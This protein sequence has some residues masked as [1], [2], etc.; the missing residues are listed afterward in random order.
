MG[1]FLYFRLFLTTINYQTIISSFIRF[2]VSSF[3]MTKKDYIIKMLDALTSINPIAKDMKTIV[4]ANAASD[5]MI[6]TLVTML[7]AIRKTITDEM[8]QQK[9][10]QGITVLEKIKKIEESAHTK[11]IADIS[12]L[13][14]MISEL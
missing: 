13:D 12:A 10:D 6:A 5:E 7:Q 14:Q 2:I 9:I 8:S 11:D 3:I 4:E 1:V